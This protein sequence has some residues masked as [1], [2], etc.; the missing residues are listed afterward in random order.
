[1]EH[2]FSISKAFRVGIL[3]K[4]RPDRRASGCPRCMEILP[5]PL[6]AGSIFFKISPANPFEVDKISS[7]NA[8][9]EGPGV[10]WGLMWRGLGP[11][12]ASRVSFGATLDPKGFPNGAPGAPLCKHFSH[13]FS[14]RFLCHFRTPIG[15]PNGMPGVPFLDEHFGPKTKDGVRRISEGFWSLFVIEV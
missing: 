11:Q 3:R 1:M 2:E 15:L 14:W 4:V 7:K 5:V 6:T 8:T 12:G 9:W 10:T 13:S